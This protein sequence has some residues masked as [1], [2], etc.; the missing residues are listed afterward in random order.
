MT[1]NETDGIGRK[2]ENIK[3]IRAIFGDFDDP[4]TK[5]PEFKIQPSMV[6]ESSPNKYHVYFFSDNIPLEGFT[7][8]QK[9]LAYN[10]GSDPKVCDLPRILRVPG[11]YHRKAESFLTRIISYTGLKYD[12]GALIDVFPP[13]PVK[14]WSA[15][16]YQKE[17]KQDQN[18]EYK[19]A[20]GSSAG[21]RNCDMAKI[22][23]GM[24]KNNKDWS[25]IEQEC[26]KHNSYSHPPLSDA[27]VRAVL[28]S[29]RRYG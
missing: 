19:G 17:F 15:P 7:G 1:V 29:C 22:I 25:Y 8:L 5:V 2:T 13:K 10:C 12:Y 23:G 14:K 20:Y 9:A 28:K 3:R 6:V 18:A 11:F 26:F 4:S 21:N 16:Q 27:E 24:L